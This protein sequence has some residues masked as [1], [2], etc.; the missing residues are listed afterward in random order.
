MPFSQSPA[1]GREVER[2]R[3]RA[4]VDWVKKSV[5]DEARAPLEELEV[6]EVEIPAS[7]DSV[8]APAG[9]VM[10]HDPKEEEKEEE[11][12]ESLRSITTVLGG[13]LTVSLHQD[14]LIRNNHTDL[15]ILKNTKDASRGSICHNATII[16]NG[17]M[18]YGTTSDTLLRENLEWLKKA[19]NWAKFTATASLGLIHWGHE[20]EALNLMASYLPKDSA[21]NS[22]YAE[23]GG[24][25]AIGLIH[26]NHGMAVIEYLGN[27]VKH[28]NSEIVRHGGCL[29]LGLAAMGTA[30]LEIYELLK[31]NLLTRDDAIIGEAAGLAMGLVM[32]GTASPIA[33][34]DMINYARDTQHEK[35]QRGLAVGIALVMYG[36]MEDAETLIED[37]C[38]DKD[39]LL[40]RS[41]MFTVAMAYCGSGDN[42]AIRRLLHVAVSDVDNNVR[43][44][45]VVL[46][47]ACAVCIGFTRS[48]SF[49]QLLPQLVS[50]NCSC[51]LA[52]QRYGRRSR[53]QRQSFGRARERYHVRRVLRPLPA[54]QAAPLQSLLL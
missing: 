40:R 1:C 12:M 30:N 31:E 18:H 51:P 14:F 25:H 38:R 21:N 47:Y 9:H 24:L 6:M 54:C 13:T 34:E 39:P 42:K 35:I 15:Q 49:V 10:L 45:A 46:S 32:I 7:H 33:L 22:P 4:R 16:S 41:G 19:S 2:A 11:W 28:N 37:L 29:G 23:G 27:E 43:R 48:V 44:A 5:E 20:K 50:Y 17:L 36:R 26:A 3:A 52:R 53:P 8:V